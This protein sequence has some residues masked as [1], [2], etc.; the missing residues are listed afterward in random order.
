[1][2]TDTF[3][4]LELEANIPYSFERSSLSLSADYDLYDTL[5]LSGGY[6]RKDI[7]RD[8]QEVAEQT[9]DIGWGRLR[10]Q[11]TPALEL[12]VRDLPGNFGVSLRQ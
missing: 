6:D 4:T 12:D 10:W 2:I 8:F 11:P 3:T 9:E 5:R 1:M 7:E